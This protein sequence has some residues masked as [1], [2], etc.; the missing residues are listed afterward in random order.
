MFRARVIII[1]LFL[2]LF[3]Y[4]AWGALEFPRLARAFPLYAAIA[5][6]LV[7]SLAMWRELRAPDDGKG[8]SLGDLSPDQEM[9]PREAYAKAARYGAWILGLFGLIW[10]FGF[11][12]AAVIFT[13]TF[14]RIG[15]GIATG[16]SLVLTGGIVVLLIVLAN[17]LDLRWPAGL[18]DLRHL[19]PFA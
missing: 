9:S 2:A 15:S 8:I 17:A 7:S 19:I 1:V 5:G 11:A 3:A 18:I 6:I 13:F 16:K 12:V 4:A 14:L 10:L